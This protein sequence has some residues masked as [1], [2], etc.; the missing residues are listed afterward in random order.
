MG[1]YSYY[2]YLNL[3]NLVNCACVPTRSC[4]RGDRVLPSAMDSPSIVPGGGGS[5]DPGH[6]GDVERTGL[7]EGLNPL[8]PP[9]AAE[10]DDAAADRG[11]GRCWGPLRPGGGSL[12]APSSPIASPRAQQALDVHN[13]AASQRWR[14][15]VWASRTE[16]V[17][18]HAWRV[19]F[20]VELSLAVL[21]IT[22]LVVCRQ[23][24]H[25]DGQI[26]SG[27][28]GRDTFWDREFWWDQTKEMGY[29]KN[30]S[31]V[32]V[33]YREHYL[34]R[35][36]DSYCEH[37]AQRDLNRNPVDAI[38][39]AAYAMC[40]VAIGLAGVADWVYHGAEPGGTPGGS[41]VLS[42]PGCFV[43]FGW[44]VSLI[45]LSFGSWAWHAGLTYFGNILDNAS[46][47][48]V[49]WGCCV[50]TSII[51]IAV[52]RWWQD[53]PARR[54]YVLTGIFVVTLVVLQV[55]FVKLKH[56]IS[57]L[58]GT[59]SFVLGGIV[60][61]FICQIIWVAKLPGPA[62]VSVRPG[63]WSFMLSAA[64]MGVLAVMLQTTDKVLC[65]AHSVWQGHAVWHA[66]GAIALTLSYTYIRA[67]EPTNASLSPASRPSNRFLLAYGGA[68]AVVASV[69]LFLVKHAFSKAKAH[70]DE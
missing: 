37:F 22:L 10:A 29:P 57:A 11:A 61:F 38:S 69:F 66:L 1:A 30:K 28:C 32:L 52:H 24:L 68:M 45:W 40:G 41:W 63:A 9:L 36:K 26:Y 48:G 13:A 8:T 59:G 20:A 4:I 53:D 33:S 64:A 51:R 60:C 56:S 3:G 15:F 62:H 67:E 39:N 23:R 27:Q 42:R 7:H 31:G 65:S 25:P 49:V 12:T 55:V 18:A 5:D 58:V 19:L 70:A 34:D 50:G 43:S 6:G 44:C 54:G 21:V 46:M 14:Q 17:P 2:Y 16:H 35:K 47:W